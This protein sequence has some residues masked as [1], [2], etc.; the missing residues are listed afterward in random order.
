MNISAFLPSLNLQS[1]LSF[2]SHLSSVS[3]SIV[4]DYIA[5]ALFNAVY[6]IVIYYS[7]ASSISDQR[8][9]TVAVN[10]TGD[11][12]GFGCSGI[13]HT[14]SSF[15]WEHN[16]GLSCALISCFCSM[17]KVWASCWFGNGRVSPMYSNSKDTSTTWT[18]WLIHLMV[19]FLP[20]EGMMGRWVL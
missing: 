13:I 16:S 2:D 8:I 7:I 18:L 6:R 9:S 15:S 12:I 14:T 1:V 11:W 4:C 19:S 17:L 5:V 20:R 3:T 10:P